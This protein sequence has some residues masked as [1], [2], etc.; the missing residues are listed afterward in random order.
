MILNLYTAIVIRSFVFGDIS[1]KNQPKFY[2][3]L[4]SLCM[5]EYKNQVTSCHGN[6]TCPLIINTCGWTSGNKLYFL[7][8]LQE[9]FSLSL[10]IGIGIHLLMD[11][12]AITTPTIILQFINSSTV[13]DPVELSVL[14][15]QYINTVSAWSGLEPTLSMAVRDRPEGSQY[16]I[17]MIFVM[18]IILNI[19]SSGNKRKR[20]R[21]KEDS[22]DVDELT[23]EEEEEEEDSKREESEA[24]FNVTNIE[25]GATDGEEVKRSEPHT[26][27]WTAEDCAVYT[28]WSFNGSKKQS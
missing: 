11:V 2:T 7:V 15:H 17:I 14:T 9:N 6:G 20:V 16:F 25:C 4:I 5:E 27:K 19:F 23:E 28:I 1:P 26:N 24:T 10:F 3:K 8:N 12:I 13:S 18:E 22:K 21:E